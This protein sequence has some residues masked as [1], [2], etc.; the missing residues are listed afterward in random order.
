MSSRD[1]NFKNFWRDFSV[2]KIAVFALFVF[3][4]ILFVAIFAPFVSP[5]DPYDL[6]S[7]SIMN[8]R[9]PP[10][11]EDFAGNLYVLGTDGAGRDMLSAIFYGLR[12]SLGVGV[13]SGL[14]A[15]II[16]SIFGISAAFFRGKYETIIMRI[17]DIQLSFP[18]ILVALIILAAFGKGVEKTIIALIL[19]QWAYYARTARASALVEINKEYIDSARCL[20][21]GNTRIMFKHILP[22]CLAPLI[23][24][25][26]LQTAHAISLEATLSFLG[27]GLPITEPSLGLLIGNGFE[28][29]YS[30]DFWISIFPGI[31]LLIT[32]ASINLV[33]DHL[34][35]MFNPRLQ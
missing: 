22:N 19:V 8:S 24:V 23:V 30:G 28:Y 13:L 20:A 2:N 33:G 34:R 14:F 18:S 4:S 16:G 17:V 10:M 12:V 32:V 21:F 6:N 5:T 27:L 7:V 35:D 11:S 26:T 3:I 9:M 31:A 15:L 29:M 25:G 1:Q